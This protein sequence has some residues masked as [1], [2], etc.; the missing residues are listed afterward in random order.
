MIDQI[1]MFLSVA[2]HLNFSA[3]AESCFVTQSTAS[4]QISALE[5]A[6]NLQLFIRNH[7]EVHLTYEGA[8]MA[9]KCREMLSLLDV[10][11]HL[12]HE[13][14]RDLS[15]SISIGIL[16]NMMSEVYREPTAAFS[17][18]YPFVNIKIER[19]TLKCLRE[20]LENN[21][22]DI[23]ITPDFDIPNYTDILYH[24]FYE[25]KGV[26]AISCKHP[27]AAKEH[28]SFEDFSNEIFLLQD[29]KDSQYR[30][31]RA[32]KL[33]EKCGFAPKEF[34]YVANEE[35]MILGILN[36]TRATLLYN[37]VSALQNS[38]QFRLLEIPREVSSRY[39]AMIH[40]E[41]SR[42]PAVHLYVDAVSKYQHGT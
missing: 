10:G 22:F 19:A 7:H 4:R 15:G 6:W 42:N 40:K 16:E 12:A 14:K 37:S 36:G 32:L 31:E 29:P 9:E 23:V 8:I 18:E 1:K 13:G 2:E 41:N 5:K 21:R 26:I 25:S 11:L 30:K 20:G 38:A 27:L 17:S 35:A 24:R 28:L 33:F 39:I 34:E 3:A